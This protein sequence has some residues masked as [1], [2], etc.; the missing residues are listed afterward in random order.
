[1]NK[2]KLISLRFYRVS[3]DFAINLFLNS[4][5][6]ILEKLD[7]Y[8]PQVKNCSNYRKKLREI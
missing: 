7:L 2:T 6:Q 5:V 3:I 8:N 1:M 4:K